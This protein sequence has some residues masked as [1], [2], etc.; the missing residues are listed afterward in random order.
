[1]GFVTEINEWRGGEVTL[2]P[3]DECELPDIDTLLSQIKTG[4]A[5]YASGPAAC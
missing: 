1:V 3:Q 2:V 4:L 5:I